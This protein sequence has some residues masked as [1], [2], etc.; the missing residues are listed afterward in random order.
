MSDHE[1][2]YTYLRQE[3]RPT[4][5]WDWRVLE[6]IVSDVYFCEGCLDYRKVDV[7]REVPDS[8]SFGWVET[9]L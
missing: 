5:Q 8:R 6:R 3:T 4:K 9:T 7:R 1:H 2:R